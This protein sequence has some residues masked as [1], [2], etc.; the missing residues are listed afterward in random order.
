MK[1][2]IADN[3]AET[4]KGISKIKN[5]FITLRKF[6]DL[7]YINVESPKQ[8]KSKDI[9]KLRKKMNVSQAVFAYLLNTNLDTLQKWEQGIRKPTKP[10]HRLFQLIEKNGLVLIRKYDN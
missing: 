4:L 7:H 3:V 5:T 6:V 2:K 1:S 10:I 8:Y 9:V